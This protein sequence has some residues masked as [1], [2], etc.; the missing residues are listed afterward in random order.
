MKTKYEKRKALTEIYQ[1][2]KS[3][4][5]VDIFFGLIAKGTNY[6]GT[7]VTAMVVT[8]T[9]ISNSRCNINNNNSDKRNDDDSLL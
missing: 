1:Q 4:F 8:I 6:A 9:L 7:L 5:L 3:R 2:S